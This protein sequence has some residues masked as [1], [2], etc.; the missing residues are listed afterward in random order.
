METTKSWWDA[1]EGDEYHTANV[2]QQIA[3]AA[4]AAGDPERAK[5]ARE[6]ADFESRACGAE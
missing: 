6:A 5:Q 1:P 4:E 2:W 3:V